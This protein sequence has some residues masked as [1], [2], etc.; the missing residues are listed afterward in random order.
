[1]YVSKKKKAIARNGGFSSDDKYQYYKI[2]N[3]KNVDSNSKDL[4]NLQSLIGNKATSALLYEMGNLELI[5]DS[6]RLRLNEMDR[7]SKAKEKEDDIEATSLINKEFNSKHDLAFD[8]GTYSSKGDTA[9]L[10]DIDASKWQMRINEFIALINTIKKSD[11]IDEKKQIQVKEMDDAIGGRQSAITELNFLISLIKKLPDYNENESIK[12]VYFKVIK[13]ISSTSID[14]D[15]LLT[16][17][18]DYKKLYD[19]MKI[20]LSKDLE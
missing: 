9:N 18:S 19:Y 6:N 20:S 13:I 5:G 11:F 12:E 14:F 17:K 16:Y 8:K 3:L 4:V 10:M 15:K 2:K 7:I 1:M